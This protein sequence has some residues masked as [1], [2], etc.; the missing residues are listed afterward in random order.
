MCSNFY[1][2]LINLF[3]G[4][5]SIF[6]LIFLLIL[7]HT[8][9][10]T[11]EREQ[12][13]QKE[14]GYNHHPLFQQNPSNPHHNSVCHNRSSYPLS[15]PGNM[16]CRMGHGPK[17]Y[18]DVETLTLHHSIVSSNLFLL[19]ISAVLASL[20]PNYLNCLIFHLNCLNTKYMVTDHLAFRV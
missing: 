14:H 4:T 16:G 19:K 13:P 17:A 3:E 11:R 20:L 18:W 8:C 10:Y 15:H 5:I 2:I 6:Y 1:I 12:R 9:I 7:S